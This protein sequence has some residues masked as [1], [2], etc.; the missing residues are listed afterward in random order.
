[1][2]SSSDCGKVEVTSLSRRATSDLRKPV[3]T[4]LLGGFDFA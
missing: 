4:L 2:A 1:M 3:K